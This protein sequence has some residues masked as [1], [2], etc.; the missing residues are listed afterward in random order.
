MLCISITDH[1]EDT[2]ISNTLYLIIIQ[3]YY[4]IFA[5]YKNILMSPTLYFYALTID[6]V[7][8]IEK[9]SRRDLFL[10]YKDIVE[11]CDFSTEFIYYN[12]ISFEL[13]HKSEQFPE[14]VH[15]HTLV[16]SHRPFVPYQEVKRTGYSV[17]FEKLKLN[18]DI[19]RWLS[20]IIKEK[21]DIYQPMDNHV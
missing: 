8:M 1:R 16:A 14:W 21:R 9:P 10:V 5:K 18:I 13:K 2:P 20:Y 19:V 15:L 11:K 17:K 12:F 3:I 4:F 7:T 6:K